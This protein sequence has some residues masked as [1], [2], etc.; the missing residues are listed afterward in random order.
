MHMERHPRILLQHG[1]ALIHARLLP[2]SDP[3][4]KGVPIRPG[5]GV[6][7]HA[8]YLVDGR[9]DEGRAAEVENCLFGRDV[10]S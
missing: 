5:G 6:R 1:R 2:D 9:I 4:A 7:Q 8:P 3:R 10:G